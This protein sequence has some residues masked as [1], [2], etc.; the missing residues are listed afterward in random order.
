MALRRL[1]RRLLNVFRPGPAEEDLARETAAHL[2][3]LEDE[4]RRRGM[5]PDEARTAARR[6]FGGVEQMKDRHRDARSFTWLDDARR[7]LH[8]GVRMLRRSPGFSAAAIVTLALGIGANTAVFMLFDAVLLKTLPVREP[9][10]LVLFSDSPSEGTA[11][12]NTP[13]GRWRLFSTDVFEFLRHQPLALSVL[14]AV[15]SGQS[16]VAVRLLDAGAGSAAAMRARAQLVS[17]NY[18][19]A[20]GVDAAAGRAL[21]VDDERADAPP[22]AVVSD[23]FWRQRLGGDASA[24]GRVADVNGTAFTIVGVTPS[25]FFG[26]RV[27]QAP[28]IWI[29]LRFQPQIELRPSYVTRADAYWLSLIGRLSPGATRIQ[30][31]TA[32]TVALQQFLSQAGGIWTTDDRAGAIKGAHI[33]LVDGAGGISILRQTYASPLYILLAVVALV[34]LIACA[35]VGNL[36]LSR[37]AARRGEV[38]VRLALGAS[39][40]RLTR[41]LLTESL[42]LAAAGA[43]CGVL[44][45]VWGA[46][47][48]LALVVSKTSPVHAVLDA[49]V[50]AFTVGVSVMAGVIFG[51]AP[52]LS[53]AR[54]DL[55]TALKAGGRSLATRRRWPGAAESL[56]AAQMAA[57]LVLLVGASLFARS[58]MNLERQPL[59]FEQEHVLLA[60][61][62]PRLAGYTPA[63]VEPLYRRLYDRL[64]VLPGVRSATLARYSPLS[65]GHSVNAGRVEG[66]TPPRGGEGVSLETNLVGPSYPETLGMPLTLGRSIGLQDALG[67][68]RAGMVNEA[69]VRAFFPDQNPLG[70]HVGTS[71]STGAVDTEIVGVLKDAQFQN[72]R[73]EVRPVVFTALL[74]DASQFALDCEIEVR[75]A[76]DPA[77]IAG[78][79][80]QAVADV[81]RN[82]AISDTRTLREQVT[83]TFGSQRLAARFVTAFGGLALVLACVGLYGVVTQAVSRR[84]YEIGLRLALGAQRRDVFRMILVDTLRIVAI[85]LVAGMALAFGATRLVASQLYGITASDPLSFAL[86]V[87]L[88]TVVATI[89]AFLPARRATRV[90]P[91]TALRCE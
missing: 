22:V 57:S 41:Q 14:A 31:Q 35:N 73:D 6:A 81:D 40:S 5:S 21:R 91:L 36:L 79:V 9:D 59:G 19:D 90:D 58:L 49:P 51:L 25:A 12:G 63:T 47:A 23:G 42:L 62:N 56:V 30:A 65:G 70:R 69:F 48:L 64:R 13:E 71:G 37:A 78:E 24:I 10:R 20:M 75:A 67:A 89:A 43:V 18:F 15:R 4:Y 2:W 16:T 53:A 39:R 7:D 26:E 1:L 84:T 28:D 3:L 8:Y 76:G 61:I 52:A 34:L 33:E 50:L 32:A 86:A 54:R 66:Y 68:T 87:G 77:T 74:Q 29:P 46:T 17:G 85:G 60:R 45:A 38:A 44:L 55:V 27:R 11:T 80:R 82:L 88:M 83:A 72:V